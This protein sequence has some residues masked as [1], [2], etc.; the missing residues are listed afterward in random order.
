MKGFI[1][2]KDTKI[3]LYLKE[4]YGCDREEKYTPL[5]Q[6]ILEHQIK[7]TNFIVKRIELNPDWQQ[8]ARVFEIELPLLVFENEPGERM[9]IAYSEFLNKQ[10]NIGNTKPRIKS[11]GAV[12][13]SRA[14]DGIS[15]TFKKEVDDGEEKHN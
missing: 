10:N 8:E 7:L 14:T 4:C 12:S 1:I 2:D 9:A 3:T 13:E 15:P 5:H 11:K 6:F